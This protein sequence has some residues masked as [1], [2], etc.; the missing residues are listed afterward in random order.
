ME[1]ILVRTLH[2]LGIFTLVSALVAE[3]LLISKQ[4]DL[5]T[6]KK[7]VTVDGIYGLGA[8]MTLTGG[9]LL[10]F[11]VGKPQEFYTANWVF[12]FKVTLFA[13]I[14][15]LSLF[16]TYYFL[17][18]RKATAEF[19]EIPSYIVVILRVELALLVIMPFLAT[20]MARGVGSF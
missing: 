10:W 19:I 7:L 16:P 8:V 1:D 18:N 3:H 12:H 20:S 5:K 4:M 15:I 13:V 6:F 14:G 2:F 17:R 11:V 9:L